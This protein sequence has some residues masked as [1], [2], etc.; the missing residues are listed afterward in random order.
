[1]A[2]ERNKV[3]GAIVGCSET[4]QKRIAE[5]VK[6]A[7]TTIGKENLL[8]TKA[9]ND[10]MIIEWLR[11][12]YNKSNALPATQNNDDLPKATVSVAGNT[13][14]NE[15]VQDSGAL[16]ATQTK[17]RNK[18]KRLER[19]TGLT[20]ISFGGTGNTK[21]YHLTLESEYIEALKRIAPAN[22]NEWLINAVSQCKNENESPTRIIKTAI[23][24]KLLS[25][26]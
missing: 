11:V 9:E 8:G 22:R 7:A 4:N 13:T 25:M 20:R 24:K 19:A 16:P 15:Q 2:S 23:V 21:R 14:T 17:K 6:E 1:M 18:T 5:V 10:N 26:V 12:N 3:I